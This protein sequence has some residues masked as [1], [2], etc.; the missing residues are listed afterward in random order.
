MKELM[1]VVDNAA[2]KG[3][4]IVP[5]VVGGPLDGAQ[6]VTLIEEACQQKNKEA[7]VTQLTLPSLP[8]SGEARSL[9]LASNGKLKCNG[10]K[11]VFL[12]ST[13][14]EAASNVL[15]KLSDSSSTLVFYGTRAPA[16]ERT[17][18]EPEFEEAVMMDLKRNVQA[19][20]LRRADNETEWNNLPLFEKYQFF[21]PGRSF[22][23]IMISDLQE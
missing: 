4:F 16:G 12:T 8:N 11:N 20:P 13:D 6:I 18:Y 21:T 22:Q 2:S 1:K 14:D 9:A 19:H 15:S 23:T 3:K 5:E 17:I 10:W 7:Q